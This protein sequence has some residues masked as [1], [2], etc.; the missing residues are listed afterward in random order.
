MLNMHLPKIPKP[1]INI[2]RS[3]TGIKAGLPPGT[4]IH[5]GPKRTNKKTLEL[6]QYNAKSIIEEQSDDAS[7]IM[8]MVERKKVNWINIDG[9]H[10]VEMIREVGEH[11]NLN[12]L[13]LE[14]ILNAEQRPKIEEYDNDIIF[15]PMKALNALS[16]NSIEFEQISFVLGDHFLLSFQEKEGDLFDKLRTRL[17]DPGNR[18]RNKTPDYLFYRLIDTVIDNYYIVMEYLGEE[19]EKIEEEVY[20]D[21]SNKTIGRI[22]DIKKELIYL[23]KALYPTREALASLIREEYKHI[24]RENITFLNDVYDHIVQ[25]IEIFETYR[26]LVS[27]LM[28]MYMS[29]ISNRMNEIMKVL[30]IISTIFI[31]MS[32][33]AGVYG[34]NFQHMPELKW[35]YGYFATL[36][37]MLMI[38]IGMLLYFRQKKWL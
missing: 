27:N 18:L 4:L 22:Q 3:K 13:M 31:P 12:T 24:D 35:Q 10:N 25:L 37:I 19:I 29:T 11:F 21:P 14:D 15:F 23:R 2:F 33:I 8:K 9:L 16:G 6:I 38:M 7:E 36:G 34:M 32:F 28:D 1:R 17:K 5:V 30:T 20:L 26:D